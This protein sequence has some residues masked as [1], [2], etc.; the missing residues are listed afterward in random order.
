MR[1]QKIK[2]CCYPNIHRTGDYIF[3]SQIVPDL[4]IVSNIHPASD[5]FPV[6]AYL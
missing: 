5:H 2:S 3:D 6:E 4:K 1:T